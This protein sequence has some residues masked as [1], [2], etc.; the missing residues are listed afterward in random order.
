MVSKKEKEGTNEGTRTT[1]GTKRWVGCGR[2]SQGIVRLVLSSS[3][4]FA[5]PFVRPFVR[6][7]FLAGNTRRLVAS[8]LLFKVVHV[9]CPDVFSEKLDSA[10]GADLS[11]VVVLHKEGDRLDPLVIDE[12]EE[13]IVC[14]FLQVLRR[15]FEGRRRIDV[16]DVFESQVVAVH[17]EEDAC[18]LFVRGLWFV[19]C[20]GNCCF[21]VVRLWFVA[22]RC[23]AFRFDRFGGLGPT[24]SMQS[25]F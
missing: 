7:S 5:R 15:Q 22:L 21:V 6:L 16:L 8:S 19:F 25:L 1:E 4:S 24:E 17:K 3:R 9:G 12:F 13:Q 14:V 10:Q 23:V 11:P 18:V 2:L 20:T